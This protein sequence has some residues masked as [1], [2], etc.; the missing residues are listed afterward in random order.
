MSREVSQ[1]LATDGVK[2]RIGDALGG[3][4]DGRM[5]AELCISAANDPAIADIARQNPQSFIRNAL[6]CAQVGLP[7]G[8]DLGFV[9]MFPEAE[10]W[11]DERGDKHKRAAIG[12]R[13]EWRGYK[14]LMERIPGVAE[15]TAHVVVAGDDFEWAEDR[16]VRHAF[17]PFNDERMLEGD[18]SNLVGAYCR[19]RYTSGRTQYV[20]M[21]PRNMWRRR[22]CARGDS[23]YQRWP[24]EMAQKTVMRF[25]W[26][27]RAVSYDP[28]QAAGMIARLGAAESFE[29]DYEVSDLT[30]VTPRPRPRPT[31]A[32]LTEAI[33]TQAPPKAEAPAALDAPKAP[34][35]PF[36]DEERAL[37]EEMAANE[38]AGGAAEREGSLL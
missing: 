14:A 36:S 13:I 19:I 35:E 28:A 10:T 32:A 23:F 4:M 21:S 17:D 5:F 11:Q 8:K 9:A 7:P 2:T 30:D 31:T 20:P 15:V 34:P 26:S 27:R 12:M 25:A 38:R 37:V 1:I 29:H 18:W 24:E 22:S 33:V 3:I 6:R 16:V